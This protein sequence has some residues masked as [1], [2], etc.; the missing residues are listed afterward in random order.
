[1]TMS[2]IHLGYLLHMKMTDQIN[3]IDYPSCVVPVT[4]ADKS[5]DLRDPSYIPISDV[6]K[7]VWDQCT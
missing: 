7:L 6:D 1:M 5:I 2:G 4:F 3:L